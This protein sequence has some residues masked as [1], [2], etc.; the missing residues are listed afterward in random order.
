MKRLVAVAN[1]TGP[2]IDTLFDSPRRISSRVMMFPPAPVFRWNLKYFLLV[3]E[4]EKLAAKKGVGQ[5]NRSA[6]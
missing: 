1:T 4:L 6:P 2:T 5:S 3:K